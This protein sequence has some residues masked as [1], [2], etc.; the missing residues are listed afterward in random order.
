MTDVISSQFPI[1]QITI[2][3][4]SPLYFPSTNCVPLDIRMD[5]LFLL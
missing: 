4:E 1:I 3:P 2:H 5:N